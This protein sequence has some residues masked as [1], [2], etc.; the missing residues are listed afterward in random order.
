MEGTKLNEALGTL[1]ILLGI[2]DDEQSGLL[3]FLIE[4]T[5]NMI[6]GYC[7]LDILPRQLE[8]LVPTI[9]ADMYRR[10]VYGQTE[11]PQTIKS[12]TEDKRSVSFES[13]LT[14]TDEFLKEY[15]ARLKP[16]VCRKGRVPSDVG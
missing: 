4:D 12:V 5:V 11:A 7:R 9:A 8:S 2:K 13:N 10:K 6:L 15:E 14:D 16:F 1:K 3:S